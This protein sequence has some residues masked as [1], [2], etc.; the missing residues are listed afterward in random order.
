MIQGR[1]RPRAYAQILGRLYWQKSTRMY[2]SMCG[3]RSWPT[4]TS[5][6]LMS[7]N[8]RP[9]AFTRGILLLP[10]ARYAICPCY[11]RLAEIPPLSPLSRSPPH[12]SP[13]SRLCAERHRASR[14]RAGILDLLLKTSSYAKN[15]RGF[16]ESTNQMPGDVLKLF[17][18]HTHF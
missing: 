15:D 2:R 7:A 6:A 13:P 1:D 9:S 4:R 5:R 3:F 11:D 18:P 14:L 17:A 16:H 10:R 12:P 8:H